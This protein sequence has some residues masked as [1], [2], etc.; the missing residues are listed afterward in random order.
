MPH[1]HHVV[2]YAEDLRPFT[3]REVGSPDY[4]K[5]HETVSKLNLQVKRAS[6]FIRLLHV[7]DVMIP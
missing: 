3:L 1:N 4:I 6:I 2:S 7:D 5:Q